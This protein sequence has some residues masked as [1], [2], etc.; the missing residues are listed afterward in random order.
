MTR[1]PGLI[2]KPIAA[3]S[4]QYLTTAAGSS[5]TAASDALAPPAG[6]A[7]SDV[8][9]IA[10]PTLVLAS[11][12]FIGKGGSREDCCA[13]CWAEAL[14]VASLHT[15]EGGGSCL[16][17]GA[18]GSGADEIDASDTLASSTWTTRV[19]RC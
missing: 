18:A 9:K 3:A 13:S 4:L 6:C 2:D 1:E 10:A 8:S 7:Y 16:L 11:G 19:R 15:S 12:Q 14:C 5:W 17:Q